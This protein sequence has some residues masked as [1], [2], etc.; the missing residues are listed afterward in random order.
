MVGEKL[1]ESS[2]SDHIPNDTPC[3]EDDQN[4]KEANCTIK[5]IKPATKDFPKDVA[6]V[7]LAEIVPQDLAIHVKVCTEV[8][9]E[10][11]NE[12]YLVST[13]QLVPRTARLITYGGKGIC[14]K[15]D[16]KYKK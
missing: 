12:L 10:Y 8:A 2:D 4:K 3:M 7:A 9:V 1:H 13:T 14:G 15:L 6:M 11:R 5:T 16:P